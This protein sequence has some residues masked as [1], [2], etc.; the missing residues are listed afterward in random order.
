MAPP[1]TQGEAISNVYL[2]THAQRIRLAQQMAMAEQQ[3]AAALANLYAKEIQSLDRAIKDLKSQTNKDFEKYL[4]IL[5]LQNSTTNAAFQ[6][7]IS[8]DSQINKRFDIKPF[9][10]GIMQTSDSFATNISGATSADA[11]LD[12]A[13]RQINPQNKGSDTAHALAAYTYD[14]MKAASAR[15]GAG[16]AN[17]FKAADGAGTIKSKI[18]AH[19]GV[20]VGD[21][22]TLDQYR[23]KQRENLLN[24]AGAGKASVS[25]DQMKAAAELA[26]LE[27]DT[28]TGTVKTPEGMTQEQAEQRLA[29]AGGALDPLQQRR[30][31]LQQ[32]V[33]AQADIMARTPEE[34]MMRARQIYRS[35]FSPRTIGQMNN[36][37]ATQQLM[38]MPPEMQLIHQGYLST[39][40]DQVKF[41][42]KNRKEIP[43]ELGSVERE[44]RE[45]AYDLFYQAQKLKKAGKPIDFKI[46]EKAAEA[47]GVE[48]FEAAGLEGAAAEKAAF[49]SQKR[50]LGYIMRGEDVLKNP[51]KS[52]P[53]NIRL[54]QE[55]MAIADANKKA[56]KGAEKREQE[57]EKRRQQARESEQELAAGDLGRLAKE[58]EFKGKGAKD[59]E[60]VLLERV[61]AAYGP[62]SEQ[63]GASGVVPAY[64]NPQGQAALEELIKRQQQKAIEKLVS[65]EEEPETTDPTVKEPADT[66]EEL[67]EAAKKLAVGDFKP[68][69]EGKKSG[70]K[71]K[72]LNP[73]GT[74]KDYIYVNTKGQETKVTLTQAMRDDADGLFGVTK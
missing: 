21:I 7:V 14:Q 60:D 10:A 61:S 32:K 2:E 23:L 47:F 30:L 24:E 38:S 59:I 49:E 26:G 12:R 17:K 55:N 4:S 16:A 57:I 13:L 40:P 74:P 29:M 67:E 37:R 11:A 64:T 18:A 69:V 43:G 73:D 20:N 46:H 36:A 71:I 9:E 54:F 70:Y 44:E 41:L 27:Y 50:I 51:L 53:N 56:I 6:R 5:N 3:N 19:F 66:T 72:T 22:T 65:E 68:Y 35:E 63:K 58:G 25:Q 31:Q 62:E 45:L 52:I 42:T 48:R 8:V 34:T 1:R 28:K 39:S 33:D 15:K